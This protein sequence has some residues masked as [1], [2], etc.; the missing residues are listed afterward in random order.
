MIINYYKKL[1][2]GTISVPDEII[3]SHINI[4]KHFKDFVNQKI[5]EDENENYLAIDKIYIA[6]K[7]WYIDNFNPNTVHTG[8]DRFISMKKRKD[9]QRYLDENCNKIVYNNKNIGYSGIKLILPN[10]FETSSC[11]IIDELDN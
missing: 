3:P 9:L 6:Y 7:Q 4:L 10:Y 1:N 2:N 8:E 11:E 5:E